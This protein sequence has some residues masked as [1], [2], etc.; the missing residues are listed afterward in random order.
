MEAVYKE[1]KRLGVTMMK[2]FKKIIDFLTLF[3]A[4]STTKH[5]E[6]WD[7]DCNEESRTMVKREKKDD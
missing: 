1:T 5:C 3:F 7:P 2:L 6:K 4:F